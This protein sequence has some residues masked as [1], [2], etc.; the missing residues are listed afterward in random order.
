VLRRPDSDIISLPNGKQVTVGQVRQ[1]LARRA[2]LEAEL[3]SGRAPGIP[4]SSQRQYSLSPNRAVLLSAQAR[5]RDDEDR[6]A[7]QARGTSAAAAGQ[8]MPSAPAAGSSGTVKQKM[9]PP[10]PPSASGARISASQAATQDK[11]AIAPQDG[12]GGVTGKRRDFVVTPGGKIV[13][14]GHGFGTAPGRV[15]VRH[16]A[17]PGGAIALQVVSWT[18]HEIDTLVP[19]NVSG[20]PDLDGIGLEVLVVPP[21][22]IS[23]EQSR[24]VPGKS[25]S[26]GPGKFVAARVE[27]T[28]ADNLGGLISFQTSQNWPGT[29]SSEGLVFRYEGG[30]S[31]NCRPPGADRLVFKVRPGFTVSAVAM[32]V[33][34]PTDVGASGGLFG[35][36]THLFSPAY[37]YGD[38]GKVVAGS[39]TLD[40]LTINWG[41]WKNH[42]EGYFLLPSND[43]C[44]SGYAVSV[45]VVGPAGLSPF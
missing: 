19:A 8:A 16:G 11:V 27:T 32:S 23:V 28:F 44:M 43:I 1:E 3:K 4:A 38:W 35:E 41:V 21:K 29:M 39:Q 24:T 42:Q 34:A 30:E 14:G 10:P 5:A 33:H 26:I 18:E 6:F 7:A 40:S 12:I 37:S 25:Y 2:R 13:V 22:G 15:L 31:V 20:L 45:S 36:E 9:Q 17:I